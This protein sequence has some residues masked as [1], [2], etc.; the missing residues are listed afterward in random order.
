MASQANAAP[1]AANNRTIAEIMTRQYFD[2]MSPYLLDSQLRF[3]LEFDIPNP[4]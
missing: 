3:N 1:T 4:A 2:F